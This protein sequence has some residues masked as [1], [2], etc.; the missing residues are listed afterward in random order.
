MSLCHYVSV[1]KNISGVV[2]E[3]KVIGIY[4]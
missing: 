3:I 4:G 1:K 2:D